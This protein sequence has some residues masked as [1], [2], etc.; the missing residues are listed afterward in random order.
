MTE[1]LSR[2]AVPVFP[3]S[4]C[5]LTHPGFDLE[6]MI[7]DEGFLPEFLRLCQKSNED[8]EFIEELLRE[9]QG[10][11]SKRVHRTYIACGR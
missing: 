3:E 7:D 9:I 6:S 10:E 1:R 8:P 11:L 4:L 2:L 5:D